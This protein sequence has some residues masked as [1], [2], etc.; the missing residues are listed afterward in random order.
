MIKKNVTHRL[1]HELFSWKTDINK[2]NKMHY[3]LNFLC[4]KFSSSKHYKQNLEPL[5]LEEIFEKVR[6]MIT[7]EKDLN[8]LRKSKLIGYFI[9]KKKL[10]IMTKI[11]NQ[12]F[13]SLEE[14][15]F[16]LVCF[17]IDRFRKKNTIGITKS[18]YLTYKYAKIEISLDKWHLLVKRKIP[19]LFSSFNFSVYSHLN[20][21]NFIYFLD[22]LPFKFK[23]VVFFCTEIQQ[24][25]KKIY[26][27]NNLVHKYHLKK[28]FN[29][30][31]MSSI[32]SVL[33]KDIILIQ[34][35]PGTG[36]TR[37]I[38]GIISLVINQMNFIFYE[39][40]LHMNNFFQIPLKQK[41][42]V[43]I[44]AIA[45]TAT[46]ENV[47]R[48]F[49]GFC[50]HRI[51]IIFNLY[52]IIR[53]GPN[54]HFLVDHVSFDNLVFVYA[55]EYDSCIKFWKNK[56]VIKKSQKKLFKKGLLFYTTV[57]CIN[58]SFFKKKYFFEILV[59]DE[60]A[61]AIEINN[62]MC[63]K[64]ISKK[65]VMVGDV[66]QLPAFVF[67]KH[68]AFF[69]YDVSL[70]KRLQLQKYAICFLEI[71]Y[72]M[73]PQISSFPARKF[74]KNGIKDSVLSDSENLY[75]LRCFSPFNFFDVSD[76][77]ENAHLKNEFSWCNLD[78]IRV[79]NLFIQLL[80]YTHQ[81][82]NAQS[83]GIISGY[84]GQV[85]EI[86]N[87][88]CNEKISKEKKTNTIDS[89]QGKEKDFIIFSCVRSRFKSGIGFLSDCRRINV[90]FTR[91]KKY[92]WCIGN[93]TSLSKNPTWKEILSDSKR[94][95][96]F[97]L[98]R[99]PF[100]RSSRRLLFWSTKDEEIYSFDGKREKDVNYSLL[101]YLSFFFGKKY[102]I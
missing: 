53:V 61:Q 7:T 40:K 77:L 2:K 35:P 38:S 60:A 17:F 5:L 52:K 48:S 98:I 25:L 88:F 67:S 34:G 22:T 6:H 9:L 26:T 76:S 75:F 36:K 37:T 64:N 80:K 28:H 71:Q 63:V 32:T 3:K 55:S 84:E 23:H 95:L 56:E 44:S 101:N 81:K 73:H 54:Y 96:K 70:F 85:D 68:S 1:I 20:E 92:F 58:H 42:K 79:I 4:V 102:V 78:E 86:Q 83:F 15:T 51:N 66:Q 30:S 62:L 19:I 89:F 14:K 90:A 50:F 41:N 10:F 24:K 12:H 33:E 49:M 18:V 47:F 11:L 45:N 29:Q 65:L 13:A 59:L 94:R 27:R 43:I 8:M 100:E 82:F 31:Q 93:S 97:F 72:R 87:Y 46:D 74:Y 21:Y 69:G 91:A 57:A 99:K 39:K 16:L